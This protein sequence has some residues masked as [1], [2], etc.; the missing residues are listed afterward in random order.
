MARK[1]ITNRELAKRLG[2]HET[3]VARLKAGDTMPRIDGAT[4]ENICRALGCQPGDLLAW[5]AEHYP[6]PEPEPE[7]QN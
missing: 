5:E 2:L 3:S 1:K 4:L 6:D 7:N